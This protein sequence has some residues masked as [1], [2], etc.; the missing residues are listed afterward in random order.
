MNWIML[1][2]L[3]TII[4]AI[5]S[6]ILRQKGRQ[7]M[8]RLF[9]VLAA[10][11]SIGAAWLGWDFSPSFT[12]LFLGIGLSTWG[13]GELLWWCPWGNSTLQ[14]VYKS[15]SR[16]F[17]CVG[18]VFALPAVYIYA[19]GDDWLDGC[20]WATPVAATALC[21]AGVLIIRRRGKCCSIGTGVELW[22]SLFPGC[23]ALFCGLRSIALLPYGV[24]LLVLAVARLISPDREA[25][26]GWCLWA[27]LL[28][29]SLFSTLPA[30]CQ[31]GVWA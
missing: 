18:A 23:F 2:Y 8:A 12:M 24:G 14:T 9:L 19:A 7:Q 11:F 10:A 6:A 25:E 13:V 31:G 28:L 16:F 30:L 15:A 22:V 20:T 1:I 5:G 21:I 29:S 26:R 4:F 3:C 27:G 17:T